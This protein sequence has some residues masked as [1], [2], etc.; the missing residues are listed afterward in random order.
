MR[1][2]PVLSVFAFT[3]RFFLYSDCILVIGKLC[4]FD[5]FN[6]CYARPFFLKESISQIAAATLAAT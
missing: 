6:L 5:E 4:F 1:D 3:L 2:C